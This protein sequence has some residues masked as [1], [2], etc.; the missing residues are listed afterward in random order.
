MTSAIVPTKSAPL[1]SV[2]FHELYDSCAAVAESFAKFTQRKFLDF[3]GMAHFF[4]VGLRSGSVRTRDTAIPGTN[5]HGVRGA[6][7]LNSDLSI[8]HSD[9]SHSRNFISS[10]RDGIS[11]TVRHGVS[12]E[13]F[14]DL[15]HRCTL[16]TRR[17]SNNLNEPLNI[18]TA[19]HHHPHDRFAR[20]LVRLP[21]DIERNTKQIEIPA[22]FINQILLSVRHRDRL[23]A[24]VGVALPVK[25][26]AQPSDSESGGI[27]MNI[28]S[29]FTLDC[30]IAYWV[31]RL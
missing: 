4:G 1:Y 24:N 12:I 11:A 8:R 25:E 17:R 31:T 27:H 15:I 28:V 14:R 7:R 5:E 6:A 9:R 29:K 30:T 23:S 21:I 22:A 16:V 3:V 2:S 20:R 18:D 26:S 10:K 13:P 19:I